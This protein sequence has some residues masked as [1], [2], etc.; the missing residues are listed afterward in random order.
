MTDHCGQRP[1]CIRW[2]MGS[3]LGKADVS[4]CC[5]CICLFLSVNT[6]EIKQK[7]TNQY[8]AFF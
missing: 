2:G 3:D 4:M 5:R 8:Y 1:L 7:E 6:E